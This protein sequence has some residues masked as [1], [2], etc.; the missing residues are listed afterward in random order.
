VQRSIRRFRRASAGSVHAVAC[1]FLDAGRA[2]MRDSRIASWPG[3]KKVEA[4]PSMQP[5]EQRSDAGMVVAA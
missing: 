2:A 4:V 1:L 5:G 3:S